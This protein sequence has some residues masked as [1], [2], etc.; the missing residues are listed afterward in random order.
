[1]TRELGLIGENVHDVRV[2]TLLEQWKQLCPD[3]ITRDA[4]VAIRL[5]LDVCDSTAVEVRSEVGAAAREQRTDD[6][7]VSRVHGRQAFRSGAPQQPQQKGFG[8]VVACVSDS[9]AICGEVRQRAAEKLVARGTGRVFNRSPVVVSAGADVFPLDENR[10]VASRR[11]LDA[12]GLVTGRFGPQLMIEVRE[13]REDEL[14][15]RVD[16]AHKMHERY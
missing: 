13:P 10:N 15:C 14:P 5:V 11:K 4:D 7:T 3:A 8:L 6:V 2:E 12:E 16:L 1:V 9:D